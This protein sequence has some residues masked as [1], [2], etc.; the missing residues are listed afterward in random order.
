M[1]FHAPLL[2]YFQTTTSKEA[3]NLKQIVSKRDE[4][5]LR[6]RQHRDQFETQIREMKAMLSGKWSSLDA[7]K[8]LAESRGVC[9]VPSFT[10]DS[11]KREYIRRNASLL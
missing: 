11:D 8:T 5:L 7:F 4:D 1:F 6:I 9:F 3:A 10:L 2:I